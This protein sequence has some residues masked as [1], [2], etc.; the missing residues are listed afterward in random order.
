[1]AVSEAPT[2]PTQAAN[3]MANTMVATARPP[4]SPLIHR[5]STT[6]ARSATPELPIMAPMKMNSGTA[7]RMYSESVP[8]MTRWGNM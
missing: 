4:L 6:K 1:M 8:L 2:T 5:W 3:I 7:A